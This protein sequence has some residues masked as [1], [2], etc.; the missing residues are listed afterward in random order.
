M[1]LFLTPGGDDLFATAVPAQEALVA[2]R[3]AALDPD[4]RAQLLGLLRKLD[5]ALE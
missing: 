3:F 5:Q 2:E 1:R 4:E